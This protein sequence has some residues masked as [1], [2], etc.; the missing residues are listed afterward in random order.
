MSDPG[1]PMDL[2]E[3]AAALRTMGERI[4]GALEKAFPAASRHAPASSATTPWYRTGSSNGRAIYVQAG[5]EPAKTD[6]CVGLLDTPELARMFVDTV[7]WVLGQQPASCPRDTDGDGNCGRTMCPHC[8]EY[9]TH[10]L[11]GE[12]RVSV[13]TW[14]YRENFP[15]EDL[16]LVL[17]WI[18]GDR[19]GAQDVSNDESDALRIRIGQPA[20]N[21]RD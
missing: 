3:L 9:P 18:T 5:A 13:L 10:P 8:G 19:V 12:P 4:T 21:S 15:V 2:R 6:V 7:N 20:A 17:R 1:S 16:D 11:T 14:E